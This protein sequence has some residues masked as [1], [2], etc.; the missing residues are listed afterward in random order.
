M[1]YVLYE[2]ARIL[3]Y[4]GTFCYS[5]WSKASEA[6]GREDWPKRKSRGRIK[7]FLAGR[8]TLIATPIL[9]SLT[10]QAKDALKK[11]S[12][13]LSVETGLM[14]S[15]AHRFGRVKFWIFVLIFYTAPAC[16]KQQQ[17][18]DIQNSTRPNWWATKDISVW[19]NKYRKRSNGQL[20]NI[21]LKE[22]RDI[23]LCQIDI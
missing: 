21:Y 2:N 22:K 14:S 10:N 11:S 6:R 3:W 7:D 12:T 9:Q 23:C 17:I 4:I 16:R 1:S 8:V 18:F 20:E 19:Y 5:P 13:R 15:A